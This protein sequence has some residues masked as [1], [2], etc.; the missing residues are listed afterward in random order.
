MALL[1][2]K[3]RILKWAGFFLS[4]LMAAAWVA[5]LPWSWEYERPTRPRFPESDMLYMGWEVRLCAG[6]VSYEEWSILMRGDKG[7][8]VSRWSGPAEWL[9]SLERIERG[10]GSG[11]PIAWCIAIP[12]WMPFLVLATPTAYLWRSDRRLRAGHC[13]S[14]GHDLAGILSGVCPGCGTKTAAQSPPRMWRF[15]MG[16]LGQQGR[17]LKWAGL[18]VSLLIFVAGAASLFW[19]GSHYGKSTSWTLDGG[20]LL[21]D[22]SYTGARRGWALRRAV[23][24]PDRG[25]EPYLVELWIPFLIVAVPTA[26]LWWIDLRR[27][28]VGCCQRCGYNL[29][30]NISGV[31]PECGTPIPAT[32]P[33]KGG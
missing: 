33:A 27:L 12:L 5:S 8:R 32:E 15:G 3:R 25:P 13:R 4:L 23:L 14:C 26:C 21:F 2:R 29:A 31:C 6:L 28:P 11:P 17:I 10:W 9:P 16:R 1:R 24:P 20:C 30:G 18:V 7:W 19:M 22:S